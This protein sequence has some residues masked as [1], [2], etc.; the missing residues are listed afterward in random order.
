MFIITSRVVDAIRS[1]PASDRESISRAL[2]N[3]FLLG[4]NPEELLTPVQAMVYA[5]IR[6]YVTQDTERAMS[7]GRVSEAASFHPCGRALG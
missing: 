7:A 2:G 5:M 4:L 1:L 6:F 3:E